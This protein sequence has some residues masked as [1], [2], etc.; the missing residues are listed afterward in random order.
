[1]IRVIIVGCNGK[2]GQMVVSTI[3]TQSD[4]QVVAGVD[5]ASERLINDFPVYKHIYEID[6]KVDIIKTDDIKIDDIKVDVIIDFSHPTN[7]DELLTYATGQKIPLVIGTTGFKLEELQLIREAA[8]I[9]P[10]FQDGNFSYG[11]SVINELLE[12]LKEK[13][14]GYDLDI[15]EYHHR[16]KQDAPSGT[17]LMWA[18]TLNKNDTYQ[19]LFDKN[20]KRAKKSIGFSSVRAGT[21]PGTHIVMFSGEDEMIEIKHTAFSKKIFALGAIKAVRFILHQK[22]GLYQMKDLMANRGESYE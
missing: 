4:F 16:E 20:K 7:L 22:V 15:I 11:V 14:A 19:Y 12:E 18:N 8:S 10:I 1:M 3:K 17:A 6:E 5:L 9:I 2:M 21:I 13:L